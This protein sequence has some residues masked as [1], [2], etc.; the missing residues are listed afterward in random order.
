M[1]R[2]IFAK[3]VKGEIVRKI[4]RKLTELSFDTNGIDGDYGNGTRK[5]IVAFQ[6]E[7]GLDQTGE[8]D[9]T[10]YEALMGAPIP[11]VSERALQLTAAFEGTGF[12]R[13]V[14]NFDG[15]GI[16]W[17][18]IGFTLRHGEL[19]KI[20]MTINDE[21]PALV[22]AAFK[23]K[24]DELLAVLNSSL[25]KQLAFADSISLGAGK[26][27]LAEPWRSSFER[28]GEFDRVQALQLERAEKD[29]IQPARLTADKFGLKTELGLSLA[30]DIHVQNGR[31]KDPAAEQ[32]RAELAAHPISNERELRVIIGNAVADKANPKFREDVRSRKLTIATGAGSVHGATY[33]LRNWGLDNLPL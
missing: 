23:T 29:Y 5:A 17:G 1:A 32:I 19:K 30:I 26:V 25:A 24:T 33:I 27:R 14:G 2:V 31:I 7:K 3:G 15:A 9:T 20:I 13:A 21:E 28:F 4:Q 16:T 8:V 22:R 18:I 12:T 10:T 6:T 11:A